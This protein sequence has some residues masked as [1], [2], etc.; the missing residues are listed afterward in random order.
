MELRVMDKEE[1]ERREAA[2]ASSQYLQPNFKVKGVTQDQLSKFQE[3]HRRRLQIK[4]K[5]KF[6][7][8]PKGSAYGTSRS[9]GEDLNSM[10]HG[11]VDA[12]TTIEDS[13]VS[14][15]KSHNNDISSSI[16]HDDV[17]ES[18]APKKRQKL[19]WGLDT[20]ERWERKANM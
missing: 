9:G 16:P 11:D 20:K 2:I 6:H 8:K 4:S 17:A 15:L 3:L 14:N 1:D 18:L 5:S 13:S 7:K 12:S 10:P 19:H